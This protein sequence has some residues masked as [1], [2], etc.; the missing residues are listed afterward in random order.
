VNQIVGT[1]ED[2]SKFVVLVLEPGNLHRLQQHR[3]IRLRLEDLFP[4]GIPQR[5]EL[6]IFYS[7]TPVADARELSKQARVYLDERTPVSQQK[8]P[9]CPECSS[10]IEQLGMM[11]D[12]N[13][14]VDVIFCPACGCVLGASGKA[15]Q[16][17]GTVT[18]AGGAH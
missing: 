3:P 13:C 18:L 6:E 1:K 2:G 10:T 7:E 12:E 4:E 5:L 9:H 15:L 11:R 14:P 8:R 16:K 17:E